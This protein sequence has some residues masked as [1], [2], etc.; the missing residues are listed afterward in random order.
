MI[1][2]QQQIRHEYEVLWLP[3]I[4]RTNSL[5]QSQ[6]IQFKELKNNNMPWYSVDHPSLIEQVAIRYIQEVWKF[7]H[8]PML[9]VLDP[10]GKPS[11][12]DAL[13]MM[14]IWGSLAFP[15]TKTREAALWSENTWN[16][17]LLVD[18]IDPRIPDWVRDH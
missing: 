2:N 4:N 15:F 10:Q 13:P 14:W 16:I 12:L 9:V 7:V 18:S 6:E 1:Y 17:E 3:I 8:M 11:N 5:S